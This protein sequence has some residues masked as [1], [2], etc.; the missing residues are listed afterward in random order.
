MPIP[1]PVTVKSLEAELSKNGYIA[2]DPKGQTLRDQFLRILDAPSDSRAAYDLNGTAGDGRITKAENKK[3]HIL[4]YLKGEDGIGGSNNE[5]SLDEA[6]SY[7]GEMLALVKTHGA[8][9]IRQKP[10]LSQAYDIYTD[11]QAKLEALN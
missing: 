10:Y 5:V 8:E 3:L 7:V 11:A 6:V 2:Y 9:K 4:E 1:D